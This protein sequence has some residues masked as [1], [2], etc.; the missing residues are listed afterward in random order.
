MLHATIRC[1]ESTVHLIGD[2]TE[3]NL[4]TLV[5]HARYGLAH[6]DAVSMRVELDS[7]DHAAFMERSQRWIRR[8]S[9]SGVQIDVAVNSHVTN[10][11]LSRPANRR[12]DAVG[13]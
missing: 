9:R 4:E 10:L 3:Y 7:A 5:D 8:L 12:A 13:H 11:L 1:G 2:L 6:G